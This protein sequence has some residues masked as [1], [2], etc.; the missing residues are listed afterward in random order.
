MIRIKELKLHLDDRGYLYETLRADDP[1]YLGFGQAYISAI[2]PE[3]IKGFHK[4]ELQ[5]DHVVCVAGQIKL[6]VVEDGTCEIEEIHLSV[7]S[8]KMVII[9][10]RHWHGWKCIGNEPA[11]VFNI[12]NFC[13]YPN[14]PD[15][16]RMDPIK[17]P[18]SYDW[19]TPL[20]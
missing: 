9:P 1:N 5:T 8:P 20:K 13:H 15:E 3:V 7:L 12:S 16:E 14:C 6:V 4:H 17:N 11:L 19:R 2:N 10:P 18:W